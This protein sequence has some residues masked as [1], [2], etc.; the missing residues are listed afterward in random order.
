MTTASAALQEGIIDADGTV[1]DNGPMFLPNRFFP[2]DLSQAQKFVS[3]NHKLGINHGPVNV[4]QAEFAQ[5][6]GVATDPLLR[7]SGL[8]RS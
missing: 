3:W 2:D 4:V 6:G 7:A 1:V 8:S 5:L